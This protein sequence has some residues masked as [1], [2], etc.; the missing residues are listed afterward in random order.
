MILARITFVAKT[1]PPSTSNFVA[2]KQSGTARL[3][4]GERYRSQLVTAS[5]LTTLLDQA[6]AQRLEL[7]PGR[8]ERRDQQVER[9]LGR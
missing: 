5:D 7:P 4:R 1:S 3:W 9:R 8:R 6:E 2:Q